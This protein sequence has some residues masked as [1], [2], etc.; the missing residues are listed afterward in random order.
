MIHEEICTYE[1]CKL[2]KEKGFPQDECGVN[3]GYY[4]WDGLRKTHPLVN[5]FA[6]YNDEYNHDNL[7]LAPTQSLLQRWLREEKGI[8]VEVFVDDDSN[9]PLTYNIHQYKDFNW[10]CV[11]HH[12]GNYYAINDWELCLEDALKYALENLV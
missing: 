1:V 4:A 9:M 6:W 5:S 2:A 8:I 7:F 12:H 11:C 3:I 10:E